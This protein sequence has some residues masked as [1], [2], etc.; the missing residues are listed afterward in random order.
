M[1]HA[2]DEAPD[3][4][5]K[6]ESIARGWQLMCM[7]VG[8]FPPSR[9]F[10][11]YLLNFVLEKNSSGAVGNYAKYTRRLEGMLSSGASGFVPSVEEIGRTRRPPI[12]STI[13]L[14]DSAAPE[15]R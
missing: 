3:E 10:E 8:A 15:A 5:P 6:P 13:E 7:C 12:L 1:L 2:A 4:Q 14:V 9:E 11:N